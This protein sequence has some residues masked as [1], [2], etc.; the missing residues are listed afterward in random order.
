MEYDVVIAG[1]GPAGLAAALTL[2]R[3]RKRVLLCDAGS[4]RNAAAVRVQNFVTRDGIAPPEFRAVARQQ[5][6]AYPNV[7]M[8]DVRVNAIT[9]D[10]G[11]FHVRLEQGA[12][13]ARRVLLCT[14]MIDELPAMEGLEP[15]WGKSVFI[16]PYCHAWEVQ[17]QR[18]AYLATD[19]D[20]LTFPLFLRGWTRSVTLLTNGGLEVPPDV[21]ARLV[22]A[23]VQVDER[24]IARLS[25]RGEHL[26]AIEFRDGDALRCDVLFM[27]PRQRQVEL[28][29][30]LGLALDSKGFVQ[31]NDTR[32]TSVPGMYAAGDLITPMQ[33]ALL[34]AASGTQ[35]AAMLN[36]ALTVELAS[37]GALP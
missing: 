33:G 21:R 2:G 14:G 27:H 10:C 28:V 24:S 9:G 4:P 15:L 35:A 6:E 8:R 12:V 3:A 18:F 31:L 29:S 11:A 7:C 32:E 23:G 13:D 20:A 16:C 17:D 36:H 5:V 26:Y 25:A 1:G 30:D 19:A 37:A 22:A 34:A